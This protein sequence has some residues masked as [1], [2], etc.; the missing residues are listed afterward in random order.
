MPN[1]IE[2]VTHYGS[3]LP[4]GKRLW[5][6]VIEKEDN[7]NHVGLFTADARYAGDDEDEVDA[8]LL[9]ALLESETIDQEL[10]D[11]IQEEFVRLWHRGAWKT[12]VAPGR[13]RRRNGTGS[14]VKRKLMG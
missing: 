2:I 12:P 1:P 7:D 4:P 13:K 8:H 11:D 10:Y 14:D 3:I 6:W 9:E 5:I